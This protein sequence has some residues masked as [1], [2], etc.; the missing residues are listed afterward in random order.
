[1]IN[2]PKFWYQPRGFLSYLLFPLSVLYY[3][4][5]HIKKI[6]TTSYKAP[7]KIICIGNASV[8][9]AGKT[10]I[11]ILVANLAL[12]KKI[13]IGFLTRGYGGNYK[14][15]IKVDLNLHD[16]KLVGDEA[17]IL[18]KLAPVYI[19]RNRIDGIELAAKDQIDL[20]IMDDGM[21]NHQLIKDL[22][23]LVIDGFRGFGNGFLLPA[24]P[25]RQSIASAIKDAGCIII[26]DY[27]NKFYIN[28]NKILI[29]TVTKAITENVS[30]KEYVA[31]SGIGNNDKFYQLLT[32]LNFNI[33][34][35]K[36]FPDHHNYSKNDLDKL[37]KIGANLITTEKDFVKIPSQ[38]HHAISYLPIKAVTNQINQLRTIIHNII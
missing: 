26:N 15:A 17:L 30:N 11:A 34:A 37:C 33:I 16:A 29:Y 21:Q 14:K 35:K 6:L 20:I 12:E 18:G 24:G 10:P 25:L 23:I 8:G 13:K 4:I 5:F 31:F 9:G 22:N 7:M 38:Y 2:T 27:N 3:I 19:A 1:M 28:T 36:S 32:D